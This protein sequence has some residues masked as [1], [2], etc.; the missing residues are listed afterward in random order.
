MVHIMLA[1]AQTELP[2][3]GKGVIKQWLQTVAMHGLSYAGSHP[4]YTGLVGGVVSMMA[5]F[6]IRRAVWSLLKWVIGIPMAALKQ[7]ARPVVA[8]YRMVRNRASG[9]AT[10]VHRLPLIGEM[11]HVGPCAACGTKFERRVKARAFYG[12][13]LRGTDV[14]TG[15]LVMGCSGCTRC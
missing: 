15:A 1:L 2:E 5:M 8:L 7:T 4:V 14:A 13:Q 9:N 12:G 3:A 10:L 6:A 11:A